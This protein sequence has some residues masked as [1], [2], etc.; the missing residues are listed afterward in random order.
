MKRCAAI[1]ENIANERLVQSTKRFFSVKRPIRKLSLRRLFLFRIL[2][3][4]SPRINR[5]VNLY[6]RALVN[7]LIIKYRMRKFDRALEKACKELEC[8]S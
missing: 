7:K 3:N 5:G 6:M 2:D 8:W 4:A 1:A